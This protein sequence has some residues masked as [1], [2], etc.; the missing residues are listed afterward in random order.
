MKSKELEKIIKKKF[1][2]LNLVLYRKRRWYMDVPRERLREVADFLFN[3]IGCRFSTASGVDTPRGFEILYHFSYDEIGL[4][5]S[6]RVL[7]PKDDPW[8]FSLT[9]IA[10]CFEWIEREI[11]E[12]L[13]IDFEGLRCKEH[14]LLAEE[15]PF[16]YNPL[17][18]DHG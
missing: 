14:L 1:P 2:D 17:R 8:T 12:L 4:V 11:H 13:G 18:R 9:P 3:E 6:P 5:V 10:P 16:D 15:I 7:I